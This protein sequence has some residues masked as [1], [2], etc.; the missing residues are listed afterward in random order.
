MNKNITLE[1][2]YMIVTGVMVLVMNWIY[3]EFLT[4]VRYMA[5]LV[6]MVLISF[7]LLSSFRLKSGSKVI[8]I[9]S[10]LIMFQLYLLF[11][12]E[13]LFTGFLLSEFVM[14]SLHRKLDVFF[15]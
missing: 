10:F 7:L 6:F 4:D 3:V 5:A 2:L 8:I 12:G 13:G 14:L 11:G 1:M 9:L 15:G